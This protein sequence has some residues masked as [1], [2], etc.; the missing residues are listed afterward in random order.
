MEAARKLSLSIVY[1]ALDKVKE[2]TKTEIP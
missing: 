1:G 2:R